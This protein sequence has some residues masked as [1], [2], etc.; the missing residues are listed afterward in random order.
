MSIF[1][2][3]ID[4]GDTALT[5]FEQIEAWVD[6]GAS[7]TLIP[8]PVL[9]RLGYSPVFKRSFRLADGNVVE[10]DLC[11]VHLRIDGEVQFSLCVFGEQENEPLL[12]VTALEEFALGVNPTEHT[13][14]PVVGKLLG[15]RELSPTEEMTE[16][17]VAA[18]S[19]SRKLAKLSSEVK[20]SALL[21]IA[22]ALLTGQEDILQANERDCAAGKANG[23][24][25]AL[26]DRLLLDPQRLESIASD[27]RRVAALPD[28]VGEVFDMRTLCNGLVAGKKRVPLGVIG[29]IYESRPNVT[30]DVSILCLKS[31]NACILRGGSE[32]IHSNA[33]LAALIRRAIADAGV[34]EDA[35]QFINNTDRSLVEPMVK[36]RGYIDLLI[37]RGSQDL[38]Q[39]VTEH[40]VMPVLAGGIGVCHTYVDTSADVQKAVDI[41][42]NAKVQRP[43]VCNA[44]DTLLV[45]SEVAPGYLPRI[46]RAW[47]EAGVELRCDRRALSILG[48]AHGAKVV[49]AREEDWG[50]EFLSLVAAVKV[51]DSLDEALEHVERY[52]SGHSEA[53]VAENYSAAMRFLDEVDAAAVYVNASTRFTDGAQL[54][55]GAE[56]GISTQKYH[57]RGPMGLREI[58]SY[59][60]IVLGRGQVRS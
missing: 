48:P 21:N 45:H 26:L 4:V 37:P 56:V 35:V 16:K 17:G 34:P 43:T 13:L 46:A 6:T 8:Y 32:A 51:V 1:R 9:E 42:Y 23:L 25:E 30:V 2:Y 24:T 52:G 39:Y 47:A 12:G 53:I 33:A 49:P 38:I 57:A 60:W 11:R 50:K 59:K 36:M 29:V 5:R 19:A 3:P 40:A 31:G 44:L 27:V 58:T 10:R 15:L 55:L 54:G 20:D 14:V 22:D 18:R 41:A 28:P 7:H